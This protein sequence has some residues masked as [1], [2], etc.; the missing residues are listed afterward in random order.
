MTDKIRENR[1][2]RVAAR[3]GLRIQKSR[4][5]DRRALGFGTYRLTDGDRDV[6]SRRWLSLDEVAVILGEEVM[7]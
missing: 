4:V 1:M 2:R 3:Q 5:R 6:D 7:S